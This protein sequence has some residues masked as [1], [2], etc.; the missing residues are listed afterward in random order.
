MKALSIHACNPPGLLLWAVADGQWRYASKLYL[1]ACS[2]LMPPQTS[3][4]Q[5]L[6]LL[7]VC[8]QR[9]TSHDEGGDRRQPDHVA[10]VVWEGLQCPVPQ[11]SRQHTQAQHHLH[12]PGNVP[13][14]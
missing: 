9:L 5:D 4:V 6:L 11:Q 7:N 3:V 14:E 13:S 1:R 10:P 12:P 8:R 2:R